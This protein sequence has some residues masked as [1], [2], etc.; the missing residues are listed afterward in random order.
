MILEADFVSSQT[1]MHLVDL[2]GIHGG[3]KITP[4]LVK[5]MLLVNHSFLVEILMKPTRVAMLFPIRVR[6]TK[7]R[8]KAEFRCRFCRVC[9]PPPPPTHIPGVA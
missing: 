2:Q 7:V 3:P 6:C 1:P 4:I 5:N 8:K 9:T